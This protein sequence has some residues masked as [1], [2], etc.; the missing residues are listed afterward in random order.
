MLTCDVCNSPILAPH[1]A[2]RPMENNFFVRIISLML[3]DIMAAR[4]HSDDNEE[5]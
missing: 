4:K 1:I 5:R 3:V 2:S